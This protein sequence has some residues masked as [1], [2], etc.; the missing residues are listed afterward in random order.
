M[1]SGL[2]KKNRYRPF[3]LTALYD[4]APAREITLPVADILD[5]VEDEEAFLAD[6]HVAFNYTPF[7]RVKRAGF[8]RNIVAKLRE[9]G[10]VKDLT[11]KEA[12]FVAMLQA[13]KE[14]GERLGATVNA[15][16]VGD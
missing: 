10:N 16:A 11:N 3:K 8:C 5:L 6:T 15:E 1:R 13:N 9:G 4:E 12:G 7:E 14:K 2:I